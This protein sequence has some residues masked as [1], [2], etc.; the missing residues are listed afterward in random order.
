MRQNTYSLIRD[1]IIHLVFKPGD[2]LNENRLAEEFQV[3]RTPIREALRRLCM[4][5]LVTITPNLGARVSDINLNDFRELVEFRFILE[6]GCAKL[7]ALN[8]TE[9]DI[10][11]MEDLK[12]KIETE[13]TEDLDKLTDFD[14]EFHLIARQASHNKLLQKQMEMIQTKFSWIIRLIN[15]KSELFTIRIPDFIEA[16]K[17]HDGDRL[18]NLLVE[19]VEY[20]VEKIGQETLKYF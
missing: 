8:A 17:E 3:S 9:E 12:T 14:A 20:S 16:M 15:Y 7:I 10:L 1:Q 2:P 11:A 19:H 18:E 5:D 13:K 4:E 6:R